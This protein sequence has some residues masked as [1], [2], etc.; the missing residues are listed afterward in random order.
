MADPREAPIGDGHS[1]RFMSQHGYALA[2]A[3]GSI[4]MLL[5]L[6]VAL[7][8]KESIAWVICGTVLL[9][10]GAAAGTIQTLKVGREGAEFKFQL[11]T[12][13]LNESRKRAEQS[14]PKP[15]PGVSDS[16]AAPSLAQAARLSELLREASAALRA[17]TSN[18]LS[19]HLTRLV[20]LS[21]SNIYYSYDEPEPGKLQNFTF[22]PGPADEPGEAH[23]TDSARS[24]S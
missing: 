24:Q 5:G 9:L 7:L 4:T 16:E 21:G 3:A 12:D 15:L 11:V 13:V 23:S 8:D 6:L 22:I 10:F 20:T 2:F 14:I 17:D 1:H 19:T 18:E